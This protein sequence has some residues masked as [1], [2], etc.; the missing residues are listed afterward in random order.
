MIPPFVMVDSEPKDGSCPA[1]KED[2]G[3]ICVTEC[4]ADENCPG[5]MKCCSNGCGKLCI[6]PDMPGRGQTSCV[7]PPSCS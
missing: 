4:V 6:E 3:G 7:N 5:K 1:V 2:M